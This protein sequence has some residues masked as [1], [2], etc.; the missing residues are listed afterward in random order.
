MEPVLEDLESS[1]YF[2]KALIQVLWGNLYSILP[3]G[4]VS[5]SEPVG[6]E[7]YRLHT[8]YLANCGIYL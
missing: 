8:I 7:K 1:L 5:I 6:K 4:Q 3:E 2:P